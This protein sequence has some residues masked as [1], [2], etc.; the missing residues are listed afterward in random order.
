MQ[1]RH[2]LP[3]VFLVLLQR[4]QDHLRVRRRHRFIQRRR[5]L[6]HLRHQRLRGRRPVKRYA[7]GREL[8]HDHAERVDVAAPPDFRAPTR[9]LLRGHV[10]RRSDQRAH[11]G[12]SRAARRIDQF[13]NPEIDELDEIRASHLRDEEDVVG[14][15][16]AMDDLPLVRRLQRAAALQE[17]WPRD[18]EWHRARH[19]RAAVQILHD[20]V[21]KAVQ[22]HAEVERLD[23]VLVPD[24]VHRAGLVEKAFDVR[25]I[26]G[27]T[28]M[29]ELHRDLRA[30]SGMA[31]EID[32]AHAAF[33]EQL[34]QAVRAGAAAD[35]LVPRAFSQLVVECQ[36]ARHR[37]HS[38]LP[39]AG[40][41]TRPLVRRASR[42][43]SSSGP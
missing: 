18:R 4:F 11:L 12:E 9:R 22:S 20:A 6:L 23:D 34:D 30:D 17:N 14:L 28:W 19:Q 2:R 15:E 36:R 41:S 39:W 38:L 13:R 33:A 21:V 8:V 42:T 43:R 10:F 16:I 32:R 5:F 40:R 7:P 24:Q 31:R 27:E 37:M 29:E 35:Q 25:A 3:A 26:A 1:L